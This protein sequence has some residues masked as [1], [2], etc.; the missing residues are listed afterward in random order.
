MMAQHANE[1]YEVHDFDRLQTGAVHEPASFKT[2]VIESQILDAANGK[3]LFGAM[4]EAIRDEPRTEWTLDF[5]AVRFMDSA[6]VAEAARLIRDPQL[7]SR[8]R[9]IG[10]GSSLRKKWASVFE[11]AAPSYDTMR[12]GAA[13]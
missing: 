5:S 12:T 9:L 2:V 7:G 1:I 11:K 4:T 8:V 6:A 10:V 3:S 13:S